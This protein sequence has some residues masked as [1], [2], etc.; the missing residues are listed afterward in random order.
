[1]SFLF[2]GCLSLGLNLLES[3]R[4]LVDGAG[5]DCNGR[6]AV[7]DFPVAEG[8]LLCKH[9]DITKSASGEG[10]ARMHRNTKVIMEQHILSIA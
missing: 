2:P 8:M 1:M 6:E 7:P 10:P 5:P 4:S 3:E 9:T